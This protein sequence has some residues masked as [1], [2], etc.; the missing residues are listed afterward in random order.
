M[1]ALAETLT[2][3]VFYVILALM[4]FPFIRKLYS[5][6]TPEPAAAVPAQMKT[7]TQSQMQSQTQTQ[8]P[9]QTLGEMIAGYGITAREAAALRLLMQNKDTGEIAA[10]MFVT[11]GTVYKYFSSMMAKTGT[12][13]RLGLLSVFDRRTI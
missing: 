4:F 2:A 8:T 1:D 13:N 3:S 10:A 9:S 6:V 12:K 7:Q 5:R 11:E